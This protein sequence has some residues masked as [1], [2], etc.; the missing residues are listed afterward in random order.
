MLVVSGSRYEL[1][2]KF[3]DAGQIVRGGLVEVAGR[4]VGKI[5]SIRLAD[6]GQAEV[7]MSIS[8]S[9]LTPLH[10]GTRATIR[11]VG[12]SSTANRFIELSPGPES[13]PKIPEGSTLP[14]TSTKGIVDL[15]QL[16]DALDE[17]TRTQFQDIFREFAK[18]LAHPTA[19]QLNEALAY[20]N[21]A[22][23]QMTAVGQELVLDQAA[24]SR[25]LSAS[26]SA[27]TAVAS[28]PAEL[29]GALAGTARA[30]DQLAAHREAFGRT[31]ERSATVLRQAR[32]TL[33]DLEDT[34]P[35]LNPLLRGLRPAAPG[36]AKLL[37]QLVPV[38]RDALP[39]FAAVQ[40]L[41]PQAKAA[42]DPLPKLADE[43]VPALALGTKALA[44][45][46]PI[47]AGLR[48]YTPDLVA[49]LFSGLGGSAAGYYDANGHYARI[50][51][52]YSLGSSG[53]IAPGVQGDTIGGLQT[54]LGARCP[55][56]ATEP[57]DDK[58]NPYT[59][60]PSVCNPDNDKK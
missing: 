6:D 7:V 18:G 54:G 20:L 17:K 40:K 31:F 27:S 11:A 2:A 36:L 37:H 32:K 44:G 26:A 22:F 58:S 51:F 15:D 29:R 45:L 14:S 52:H 21:P 55:G 50:T 59:P 41:L 56:A 28:E 5:K 46:L 60:D 4:S 38:T 24:F 48:P 30:L 3:P 39:T 16:L 19:S 8:D 10:V 9:R 33:A 35:A 13:A 49:G 42:L 25:L 12:L 53:Q 34:L 47:V 57:A 1:R 23:T 43:A